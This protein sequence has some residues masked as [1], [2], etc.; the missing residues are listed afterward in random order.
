MWIIH[1]EHHWLLL[2][3]CSVPRYG[4]FLIIIRC[5][6]GVRKRAKKEVDKK[7]KKTDFT[8]RSEKGAYKVIHRALWWLVPLIW[9]LGSFIKWHT[10]LSSVFSRWH[11][12][13]ECN[14]NNCRKKY[15]F[16]SVFFFCISITSS[17]CCPHGGWVT[18]WLT[19]WLTDSMCTLHTSLFHDSIRAFQSE[20]FKLVSLPFFPSNFTQKSTFSHRIR[21]IFYP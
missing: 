9:Q 16:L 12:N 20:A 1:D 7:K 19:D 14:N 10:S 13:A 8:A 2:L 6:L 21:T 4:I 15:S 11:L 3:F 17:C 5:K 18:D